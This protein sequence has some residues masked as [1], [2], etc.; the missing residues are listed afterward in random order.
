MKISSFFIFIVSILMIHYSLDAMELSVQYED[1]YS[2]LV[3]LMDTNLP[4]EAKRSPFLIPLLHNEYEDNFFITATPPEK[5]FF[6]NSEYIAS[7]VLDL[8]LKKNSDLADHI[9]KTY[10]QAPLHLEQS[11]SKHTC[12]YCNMPCINFT[13]FAAHCHKHAPQLSALYKC[14]DLPLQESVALLFKIDK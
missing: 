2:S 11:E 13:H 9:L 5:I 14:L 1:I 8:K 12:P 6:P 4:V 10:T 7:K 3:P